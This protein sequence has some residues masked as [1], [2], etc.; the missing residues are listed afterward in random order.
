MNE[1]EKQDSVSSKML[2]ENLNKNIDNSGFF[3]NCQD[4]NFISIIES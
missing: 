1:E 2:L 4:S 3:S